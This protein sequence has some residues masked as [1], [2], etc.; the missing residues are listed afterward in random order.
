MR[1]GTAQLPLH[2]GRAPAWLFVRMVQLAREITAHI[3]S[4]Y[5]S[6][7]VLRRLADPYWFQAFGCV[8]GFDWH[9]SGVTTTVTGAV[10][11]GREGHRARPRSLCRRGQ[12]S[13]VTAD[14]S[15]DHGSLRSPVD[16]SSPARVCQPH[17]R[18]GRQRGRAGRLPAL[19]P[20]V[21]LHAD[22]AAGASCSRAWTTQTVWRGG[23]TGST[24][25]AKLRERTARRDLRRGRGADAEPRGR[26]KRRRARR[27]CRARATE[28]PRRAVGVERPARAVDAEASR[29]DACRRQPASSRA[30]FS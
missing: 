5:G 10:K 29:C 15:R 14:A 25:G 7:E 12:G 21:L 16:R 19:S 9:S 17:G 3:V 2:S 27:V 26:R 23:I 28:P 11:E 22:R 4:E 1:S 30:R 18:Q 13:G 20:R 24:R 8:L 6:D